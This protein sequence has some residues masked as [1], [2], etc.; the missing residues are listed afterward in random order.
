MLELIPGIEQ[1]F[2]RGRVY[3]VP[4]LSLG[5][6]QRLQ[7]KLSQLNGGDALE[8]ATVDTVIAATHAALCRN[9]PNITVEDVGDLVD[10]GNMHDVISSLLDVAGV[11][12][13]A[14]AEEKNRAA[15]SVTL[16]SPLTGPV[17]SQTSAPTPVGPGT[18]SET[19]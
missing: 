13:K 5:A 9:Y 12:R 15:Q 4:P 16:Q 8:P 6:L 7:G 1:N 14:I 2:G 19:T 10:V 18:T 11:K 17:S 3:V